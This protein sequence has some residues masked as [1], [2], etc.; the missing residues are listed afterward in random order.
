[1]GFMRAIRLTETE[2]ILIHPVTNMFNRGT[3][4]KTISTSEDDPDNP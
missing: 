4:L 3:K 2:D 1:M